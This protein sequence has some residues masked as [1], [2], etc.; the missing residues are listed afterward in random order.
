MTRERLDAAIKLRE[1]GRAKQDQDILRE[2]LALLAELA[3]ADP[4]N[5]EITYQMAVAN[6]NLGLEHESIPFYNKALAQGLA[7]ADQERALM[8]LGSTYR[9]LGQYQQAEETLRRGM[10]EFPNNRAIQVFLAM[11]LYNRQQHKE[12]ME[13][14]VSNLLETTTD[15][16]LLYFKRGLTYYGTHLDEVSE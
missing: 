13:L 9:I 1:D 2:A 16:K 6:D 5:A 14:L 15:E 4:D 8:G 3:K 7:G 12:A 11:T 10:C